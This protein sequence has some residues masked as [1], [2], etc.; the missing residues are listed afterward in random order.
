MVN[1]HE[2]ARNVSSSSVG[3]AGLVEMQ[4]CDV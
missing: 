3:S 1:K 4:M 2:C